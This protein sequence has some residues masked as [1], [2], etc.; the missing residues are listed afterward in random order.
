MKICVA[1]TRPVKGNIQKNI[2]HHKQ[3][4]AIAV[5]C[6]A[7]AII[8]P[9]LSLTGYEP[10]L[11]KALATHPDD[12]RFD[13]FQ[14]ISDIHHMTIGV[15]VPT[16]N[17]SGICISLLLFQPQCARQIYSKRYLHQDEEAFFVSGQNISDITVKQ[18]P[19]ALAICYE[20]SVP[21]HREA[22]VSSGAKIYV[23]SVAKFVSGIDKALDSL[24]EI[25]RTSSMT[26]LMSNCVGAS[27]GD[28]CAGKTSIWN[29]KGLLLG[30]L[31]DTHEGILL[32]DTDAQEVVAKY[33]K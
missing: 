18:I 33:V 27:D 24:S 14:K 17:N 22:A 30:Q 20:I 8:F 3:L 21:Q 4:I 26:V 32:L 15:G 31:D 23:A 7:D 29:E 6:K 5:S 19:L 9:E 16:K 1:Q 10:G 2:E 12:F 13:D 11:A 25:A 28:I